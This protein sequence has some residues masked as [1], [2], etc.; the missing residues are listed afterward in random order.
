MKYKLSEIVAKFGGELVG[1]DVEVSG[2]SPTDIAKSGDLTFLS[3]DKYKKDLDKC[4]ASAII[5][6]PK[7]ADLA[8]LPKIVIDNPYLYFAKVSRM[9]NPAK[10]LAKGIKSTVIKGN[11]VS[12]AEDAAISDYVVIGDNVTIGNNC[13]IYPHVTIGDNV[14]IGEGTILHSGVRIN[15]QV[16][17][18]HSCVVYQNAVIGSDG[19]GYAPDHKKNWHKI[20]QVGGVIVGNNVEIGANTTIDCGALQPTI[21]EDGV[22]I[23]NLVQI[24]HNVTIGAHSAIAATVGIAGGTKIGKYCQLAGGSA[25]SGHIEIADHTVVGGMTGISKSITKPGL[26]MGAYPFEEYREYAK[27]AVQIRKLNQMYKQIKDLEN[28]V[29]Q[30]KELKSNVE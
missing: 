15:N 18:G 6:D 16:T 14:V 2:I 4:V 23:D 11:N 22:I 7:S 30:L 19:F 24:A 1:E 5:I 20:P 26:Y 17:L 12:I 9:F 10:V 29:S 3:A 13:Q 8:P 25:L 28:V 21:I 27:N